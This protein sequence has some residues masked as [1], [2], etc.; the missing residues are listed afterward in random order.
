MLKRRR[1]PLFFLP[2]HL[3]VVILAVLVILF[4]AA[5]ATTVVVDR[6]HSVERLEAAVQASS[7]LLEEHVVRSFATVD[8]VMQKVEAAVEAKGI[9]AFRDEAR[10]GGA[11]RC[12]PP[13][14][15]TRPGLRL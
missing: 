3:A 11:P 12:R 13:A 15:R 7:R 9:G 6:Q 14:S 4:A 8:L 2:K 5:A 1:S 10:L